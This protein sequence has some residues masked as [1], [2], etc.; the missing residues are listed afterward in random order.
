MFSSKIKVLV[1]S[2]LVLG[3][4]TSAYACG[5]KDRRPALAVAW[6]FVRQDALLIKLW[7]GRRRTAPPA[8]QRE[9]G[10]GARAH[11]ADDSADD[12]RLAG[13]AGTGAGLR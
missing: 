5:D 6:A 4:A 9:E 10:L 2:M 7:G 11:C 12:S 13:R 3:A 1:L 8:P